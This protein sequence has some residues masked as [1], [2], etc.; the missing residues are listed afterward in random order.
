MGF[1]DYV[2][3]DYGVRR[4]EEAEEAE[5]ATFMGLTKSESKEA[6]NAGVRVGKLIREAIL[7]IMTYVIVFRAA[8]LLRKLIE[9]V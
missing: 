1:N 6:F 9:R 3:K 7:G 2:I 4:E 8:K 5:E